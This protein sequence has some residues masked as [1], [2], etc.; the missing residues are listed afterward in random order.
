MKCS[1]L[2][3]IGLSVV[4]ALVLLVVVNVLGDL[5]MLPN[6]Y[7]AKT[8]TVVKKAEEPAEEA[9]KE[10]TKAEPAEQ[11][12]DV[13]AA[14]AAAGEGDAAAGKKVFNK[15]KGCH[16]SAAGAKAKVGPNLWGVVGKDKASDEGYS[17]SDALKG[18]G[19]TWTAE[20]LDAFLAK[21][22]DFAPGT[23]MGF[24]GLKKDEDRANLIAWLS[25]QKD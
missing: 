13:A 18:L 22:K 7:D 2:K 25:E 3:E 4:L 20:D 15:C 10:E 9:P 11:K 17:Y 23:K 14:P 1:C 12:T 19:G 24:A 5:A 21:P 6:H 8:A 16:N